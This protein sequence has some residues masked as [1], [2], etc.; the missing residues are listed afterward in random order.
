MARRPNR[1]QLLKGLAAAGAAGALGIPRGL[2][3]QAP[4]PRF[5]VVVCAAGGAS[6][7]DG[8]LAIRHSESNNWREVNA[9]PDDEVVSVPGTELRAVDLRR[10]S[11][12]AIPFPFQ[13]TQSDFV[14]RHKDDMLVVTHTGTSV[15]HAIAQ[16]R[17]LTGNAAWNGRT[18]QEAVAEA[19]G[20]GYPLPNVNMA[21]Q[22]YL[23]PGDDAGL[24]GWAFAEPVANPA[25]WTLGLH[26]QRGIEGAPD[27]E[28][29][30]LA[31]R[32]RDEKLDPE[33]TFAETFGHSE[34]LRRWRDHR[35]G[36]APMLEGLDL[37]TRLN[38]FPDS[39]QVP[40]SRYGLAESPDG[41]RVREAF[42]RYLTDPLEA[43][44]ALAFLLL[45]SRASVTVTIGPSFSVLL[46]GRSLRNPPL[47]FDFSHQ[48]HRPA[49]A[50]MW[51]RLL[52]VTD[53]LIGLLAAEPL[54]AAAGTSFW[55][56]T[57]VYFATEFGRSKRRVGGADEFGS[58]HHLNNGSLLVS[59]LLGGNRVLGGVDPETG[60]TYGFDLRT[61][62]PEPGR[63]TAE[64]EVFA[65]ILQ[66]L[67]VPH[68]E[69]LPDVP[70]MRGRT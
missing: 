22:G 46:E 44:A 9:F 23:S 32:I 65:G 19:Y 50:I 31:R 58:G 12:G 68:P 13:S 47:A 54:D 20:E 57:L 39:D 29:V 27:A 3:A 38:V 45:K 56:R 52:S 42:P 51:N 36:A 64:A 1:R 7:I 53:R 4:E 14:R 26:G 49:Q 37:I 34:R 21:G 33:S 30:D 48:A 43:Q 6:I 17:S 60:L 11:A 55:D 62:A 61:G 40:L 69:D 25:L 24:P 41:A 5:L 67:G 16:K 28:L 10:N 63:S 66:A 18:L 35:S 15:N 8:P 59:P 70:A 2:R